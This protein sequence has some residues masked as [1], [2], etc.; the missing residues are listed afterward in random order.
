M[1]DNE[2]FFIAYDE[3]GRE[4]HRSGYPAIVR[5]PAYEPPRKAHSWRKGRRGAIMVAAMCL[6][7]SA[8]SGFAGG[9]VAEYVRQ[10]AA[11]QAQYGAYAEPGG[12]GAILPGD[13]GFGTGFGDPAEF[14][15][16]AA[17]AR[18]LV[19]IIADAKRTVVEITTGSVANRRTGQQVQTGAGSGVIISADGYIVTN[20]HVISGAGTIE[21]RLADGTAVPARIIGADAKTDLAVLKIDRAGLAYAVLGDSSKLLVGDSAMAIGN[22]LGELGG[23]V[24][25]GIISALDREIVIDGEPMSLL[26]TDAAINPGNSGGG[27]FNV[28]GELIGIVNAKSTGLEIEGLGFAIPVNTAKTVASDIIAYGY[29]KGRADTGF[30]VVEVADIQSIFMFRAGRSGLYISASSNASFRAGDQ[31]AA[32][33]GTEISSMYEYNKIVNAHKIGDTIQVSIIR[34]GQRMTVPVTLTEARG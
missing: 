7:A 25:G 4:L 26:Q 28:R 24:T 8:A 22:P 5:A 14:A 10:D 33:D 19:Q 12:F 3:F 17:E 23:T 6:V 32:I 2:R 29:V 27:L 34:G 15:A 1:S 11:P 30:S 16:E 21:A 18:T 20:A 31:I 13:A 9:Y